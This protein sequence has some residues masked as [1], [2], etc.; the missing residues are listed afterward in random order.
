MPRAPATVFVCTACG[1]ESAKWR[2]QCPG[3]GEWNTLAEEARGPVRTGR[4]GAGSRAA[5]ARPVALADVR[6]ERHTRLQTGINELDRV[7]GGGI[8]PGSL[9]LIGGSPG[10]GKSTLTSMALGNLQGA[11]R[12]TLYVSGEESAAQIR[13]RAERLP[14]AALQVPVLSETDLDA[15]LATIEAEKPEVCVVD[16]VQTLH[17]PELTGAAGSVGQVREV[18]DRITR[19]AKARNIAVLLVGHVTKEGALAG[20]RVLEHLVDCVLQFEGERERTYRTLRALKNRFGSTN[21]VGVFEMRGGG[22]VEV[23]DASA[24]FVGEA[25]KAPGSVV[26]AAMEGSRPLLVEVQALVSPS[27]LVPPRRV[28]NGI[29]RNRLALVLAVLGRHAGIGAGSA[30]VFVNVAGGV[31]VDEPGADLAVAL[32]VASAVKNVTLGDGQAPLAC[33]GEIGL[34]GE[35]R[36]VAHAERRLAEAEKFGLAPV[37]HPGERTPTLRAAVRAALAAPASRVAA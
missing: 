27:E 4:A 34:T 28:V 13:L 31:R 20:P 7:L 25:T 24:R 8:V 22:L 32:A 21:D 16:S 1:A 35:L 11:G 15:V 17:A 37:L 10:I 29:D 30:D 23:Q 3:C 18:A 33:F 2:G 5:P 6:A 9:V 14:G 12:R 36:T 26:L 19:L